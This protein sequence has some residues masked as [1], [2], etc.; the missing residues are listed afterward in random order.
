MQPVAPGAAISMGR[1]EVL[2]LCVVGLLVGV[3]A[4]MTVAPPA[5]APLPVRNLSTAF[6]LLGLVGFVVV[7]F[8]RSNKE[9]KI[10]TTRT[11]E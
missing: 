10:K 1:I 3:S 4:G 5:H 2:S 6:L 9:W 8:R 7:A 11:S